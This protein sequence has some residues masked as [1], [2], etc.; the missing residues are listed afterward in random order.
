[1]QLVL[2]IVSPLILPLQPAASSAPL[3]DIH[4]DFS[5]LELFKKA[6]IIV[7]LVMIGLVLASV[8]SWMIVI[9]KFLSFRLLKKRA[10]DFEET[11]WSGRTLEELDSGLSSENR[12]PM[13]RV[14]SAAMREWR[15]SHGGGAQ[16]DTDMIG[17][18]E[19]LDRIMN[20]VINRELTK[21]E[22]GLGVLATVGSA[23]P[24]IGLFGTVWGIMNSFRAVAVSGNTGLTTVLP[25]ITE[26][27]FA[28]ALGLLA[29][30][31]AVIFYN[32]FSSDLNKYA[33]RLEGYADELSAILSRKL[34]KAR[35]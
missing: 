29:A 30:I 31:P 24:F 16:M 2:D 4:A 35:K 19:R 1:M 7:K 28:T 3:G 32:K 23:S 8:W 11:F 18:R 27:L 12:D 17:T 26:A 14:F 13:G 10:S 5:F 33:G 21:A 9:D 20:L 22:R 6:D 15:E 34:A 25:G